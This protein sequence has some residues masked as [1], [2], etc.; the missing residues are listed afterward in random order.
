M[1]FLRWNTVNETSF[2]VDVETKVTANTPTP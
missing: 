2:I 1:V